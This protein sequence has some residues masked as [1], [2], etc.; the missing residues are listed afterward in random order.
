[1]K[2]NNNKEKRNT[3]SSSLGFVL[4]AAGSAVGLGNIWRFPYLAAKDGGGLF[5]LVYL[6][7][8]LTFGFSLLI[9]EISIGRKS[10][11]SALTAYGTLHK[12]S[13]WIG[14]FASIVPFLIFPYYC[15][16]GGWVLKYFVAFLTGAAPETASSGYFGGFITDQWQPIIFDVIFLVFT[17]LVIYRGVNKGIESI[18]KVLMPVLLVFVIGISIFSLTLKPEYKVIS[19]ESNGACVNIKLENN[20]TA[21]EIYNHI[22]EGDVT[23]T[24]SNDIGSAKTTVLPWSTKQSKSSGTAKAGDVVLLDGK[25]TI[26]NKGA[27]DIES[28]TL[29]F[30]GSLLDRDEAFFEDA[31]ASA[32]LRT[33]ESKTGLSGMKVYLIPNFEGKTAHDIFIIVLDAMGQLFYSISVAMGIMVTYGS[34]FKDDENLTKSVNQIEFFDTLVAFL[35]GVMIIPAVFSF[36]GSEGMA[37]SGPGLMFKALPKVFMEMGTIGTIIGCIFFFMVFLAALTSSISILETVVAS[38]M[39]SFG[40]SRKKATVLESLM[41][42]VIG[43]VVCLGYNVLFFNIKLPNGA[44]AQ[45]LD[46]LDYLSNN[47]F[48]PVVAIG[49]CILIGWILKPKT[50]IEE[51]T[52]NGEKLRRKHLYVAMI[53]FVAPL[54]LS[55][56]LLVSLGVIK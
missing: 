7:L 8:A 39:D 45:I 42:L 49:T 53:K 34:Y 54:L 30:I 33:G 20:D 22:S 23:V 52:K 28:D 35:A 9:S 27:E 24:L 26:L 13:K 19:L 6:I 14:V 2:K 37:N 17:A 16:I 21:N 32:V 36:M 10:K 15:V 4:A 46:L 40:W 51:A 18:S 50:V 11:Q 47:I 25:L 38:L 5:L 48:M 29:V 1:M 41:G 31:N 3:F 56:L 12:K 44:D 55:V 43:I